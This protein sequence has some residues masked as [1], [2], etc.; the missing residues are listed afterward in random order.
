MTDL[1]LRAATS[2]DL[3][4][5]L[6]FWRTAAEGTSISDDR[7][8]VERLVNRHHEAQILAESDGVLA[9]TVTAEFDS[10]RCH[11]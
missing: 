1:R 9:G 5:V 4:T 3:D 7:E 11:P 10:W 6:A 2:A 8:G